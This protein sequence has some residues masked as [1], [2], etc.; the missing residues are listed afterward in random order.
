MTKKAKAWIF[1]LAML[2]LFIMIA[3][4]PVREGKSLI[5]LGLDRLFSHSTDKNKN[6]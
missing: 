6:K 2:A 4:Y 1:N 5:D 3:I